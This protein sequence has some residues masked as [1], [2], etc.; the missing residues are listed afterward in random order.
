[1]EVTRGSR[2]LEFS[3]N[4]YSGIQC[5]YVGPKRSY[6]GTPAGIPTRVP[7]VPY[8]RSPSDLVQ[9]GP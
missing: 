1:M 8:T 7:N 9:Q 4:S 2:A 3:R 5:S 6:P